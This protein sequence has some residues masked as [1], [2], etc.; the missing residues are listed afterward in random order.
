M[1]KGRMGNVVL[2]GLSRAN[3]ERLLQDM[4]I[5]F[6]GAEVAMPGV[7]FVIMGG[8]SEPE[9]MAQL[10]KAGLITGDTKVDDRFTGKGNH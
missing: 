7:T 9:M 5:K 8:E 2:I 3:T 10:T 6:D 4:P 1:I